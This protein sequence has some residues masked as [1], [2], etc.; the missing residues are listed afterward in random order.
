[1]SLP[2]PTPPQQHHVVVQEALSTAQVASLA[3]GG[4]GWEGS[5]RELPP[6]W[7][8]G[9]VLGMPATG[10]TSL[11]RACFRGGGG[12]GSGGG[13][14]DTSHEEG[15]GFS[16]DTAGTQLAHSWHAPVRHSWH[17]MVFYDAASHICQAL[18]I[19]LGAVPGH[20]HALHPRGFPWWRQGLSEE[21]TCPAGT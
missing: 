20:Q 15:Q 6:S 7:S 18:L 5:L 19:G 9:V 13:G 2:P 14:S 21:S 11:M 10:K 12:G 3:R 8:L 16:W 1:M 4:A 17:S